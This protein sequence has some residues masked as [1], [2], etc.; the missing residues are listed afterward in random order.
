M[1]VYLCKVRPHG[2][3][4]A[5]PPTSLCLH[6]L[7]RAYVPGRGQNYSIIANH[8]ERRRKQIAPWTAGWLER[9]NEAGRWKKRNPL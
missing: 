5:P 6:R 9:I 4:G 8:A 7:L 1:N 3:K 2:R